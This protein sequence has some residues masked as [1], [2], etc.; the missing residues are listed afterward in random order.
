MSDK[1]QLRKE[2]ESWY[3]NTNEYTFSK[4]ARDRITDFF[5]SKLSPLPVASKAQK[6]WK[7]W[8]DGKDVFVV[9]VKELPKDQIKFHYNEAL[10]V[11]KQKH[12][13]RVENYSCRTQSFGTGKNTDSILCI[14]ENGRDIPIIE[15]VVVGTLY[16]LPEGYRV[17]LKPDTLKCQC[18][19]EGKD[20]HYKIAVCDGCYYPLK[21]ATILPVEK[22]QSEDEVWREAEE[23]T[24]IVCRS[25][26][27]EPTASIL[28]YD[29]I[30]ALKSKYTITKR[31]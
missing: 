14:A 7:L 3:Q 15:I 18:Q 12:S 13:V 30:H 11:A 16:H 28:P 23:Q 4:A 27:S 24:L 22:Q 17:E 9:P 21:V 5:Y 10:E 1:E 26:V 29:I 8:T 2:F 6:E 19:I 25:Y 31:S 20:E